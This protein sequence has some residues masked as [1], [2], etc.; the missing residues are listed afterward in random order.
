M[1]NFHP[2]DFLK[3]RLFFRHHVYDRW[4]RRLRALRSSALPGWHGGI[5]R[6]RAHHVVGVVHLPGDAALLGSGLDG[7]RRNSLHKAHKAPRSAQRRHLSPAE[8]K[9]CPITWRVNIPRCK[10]RLCRATLP[11]GTWPP[12]LVQAGS[13]PAAAV[14]GSPRYL[15][16]TR[17]LLPCQPV[18]WRRHQARHGST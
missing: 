12:W 14:A 7:R 18:S 8:D 16:S 4:F 5:D 17:W 13:A 1:I 10:T 11:L 2:H 6:L 9:C 15:Q 3:T